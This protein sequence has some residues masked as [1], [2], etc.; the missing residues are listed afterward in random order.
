MKNENYE[1]SV[2]LVEDDLDILEQMEFFLK[3]ITKNIYSAKNGLEGLDLFSANNID[4]IITDVDMPKMNGIKMIEEIREKDSTVPIILVTGLKNLEVLTKAIDLNVS[5]FLQKPMNLRD[6]HNKIEEVSKVKKLERELELNNILLEQYK[7]VVDESEI[8]SKTDKDGIITY[9]NEPFCE[10][11]GFKEEELIG[12]SH[13]I[14]K[15]P[16][17]PREVFA[18]IW[19]TIKSDKKSWKG[20]IKNKKKDGG[21]YWVRATITP[22]LDNAGNIIEFIAVRTDITEEIKIQEYFEDELNITNKQFESALNLSKEY[23]RA[24]NESNIL[25]RTDT[26]GIITHVNDKFLQVSGYSKEELIGVKHSIVKHPDTP[27]EVFQDLWD[28]ITKG[29]TWNG[30]IKNKNKHKHSYWVNITIVP[31]K[32]ENGN[33]IEYMSIRHDLTEIFKLHKEIEDTQKE[34]VYKMGE[35]G[36]TRSKET[37]NHVKRVAEY[38][39]ILAIE[40]GLNNDEVGLIFTASPMHDIGKVGIA[41]NILKKPGKLTSEE[42]EIMKTHSEIGYNI[43]RNSKRPVLKAAAI[44]SYE[45]HEKWDGSGYPRGLKEEEIHIY[46]RITAIA[47]VF[48]ALGSNRYYKKAWKDEDIFKFMEEQKGKHFDPKLIDIFFNNIDKFKK[49]RD[50]FQDE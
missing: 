46:G 36:E 32:D 22:I 12:F 14:V 4:L 34:I 20:I 8:V 13:N 30:V 16:D 5:K 38:S 31:I 49:I 19:K 23:E 24:I 43:L 6:L 42:W 28:T 45:H 26:N 17:T 48:D 37:G 7:H 44:I 27:I 50:Q 21:Y 41:D 29:K 1:I 35:I 2:L 3:R 18:D 47:D 11:S 39:R 33:I 10:I 40:Y 9:V 25:S 15:H